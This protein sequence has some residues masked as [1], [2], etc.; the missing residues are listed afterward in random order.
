MACPSAQWDPMSWLKCPPN[1]ILGQKRGPNRAVRTPKPKYLWFQQPV[2]H[3]YDYKNS[4][5]WSHHGLTYPNAQ[6]DPC[7][8]WNVLQMPF[9]V[10]K[11]PQIGLY[12]PQNL[13]NSCHTLCTDV[14]SL[15]SELSRAP[16]T[17]LDQRNNCHTLCTDKFSLLC[18]ISSVFSDHLI[19]RSFCHIL[20]TEMVFPL[21]ESSHASSSDLMLR[22]SCYKWCM[23]VVSLL[24]VSSHVSSRHLIGRIFCNTL[25]I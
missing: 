15:L 4:R 5:T 13:R 24:C 9:W 3:R 16:S 17:Y 12:A 10:Q 7:H 11:R 25:Y 6:W 8:G 20:C 1:T 18:G 19:V 14:V 2:C 22:S 21:C 23:Y